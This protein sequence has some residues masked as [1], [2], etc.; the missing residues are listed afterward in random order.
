M[1]RELLY[2]LVGYFTAFNV[3]QYITFRA[4]YAAITALFVSFL[5]GPGL[6]RA[7]KRKKA[8]QEIRD[9]GPRSHLVKSGTPT[10]GGILIILS[11]LVS[12][13][14]WQD[15]SNTYTWIILGSLVAFGLLGFADDYL[16][17]FRKN[18]RGLRA[19]QKFS[20]QIL[21]SLA[22]VLIIY[23]TRHEYTTLLY[24]P[25]L[26][27]P[28]LDL[29]WVY[30]PI[31][32]IYLTATSNMVNLTDGLDGLAIGLV[33]FVALAFSI[34]AYIT[35]RA[36]Y[37]EYLQIPYLV[38]SGELTVPCFALV[39]ASVGFLWFNAHPAEIFMGDTGS[40]SL[41]GVI[42]VVSLLLKK[43]IL[44]VII[45]GVFV[46]EMLSVVIQVVS[47]KLTSKRVFKMAPLHHH[48][49]LKGWEESKVVIRLWIL[50]GLFAI[51]SLST[52]KLQ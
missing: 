28:V 32:V 11:V 16:K 5:L 14:L 39:G 33:L 29:S 37:A 3:F 19:W 36:D 47:Y 31:A 38:G 43:E 25:F 44:L 50:G 13:V 9:D 21:I 46:L 27:N 23:S 10:M 35:G 8:G 45:G 42:G 48:F 20:G 17:V 7:L 40:I 4:A 49:E 52:L 51:L 26:K 41:G 30:I 18:S 12:V 15:L 22:I 34:L 2:P 1:L 6:I 24:L